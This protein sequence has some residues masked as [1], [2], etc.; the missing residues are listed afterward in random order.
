MRTFLILFLSLGLA[1]PAAAGELQGVTLPDTLDIEGHA[2]ALNGMALRKVFIVKVYVAGLY[3][4]EKSTDADAVL[5]ADTPR[6]ME[7]HWIH[8]GSAERVCEGWMEGLEDNTPD[9]SAELTGQFETLCEWTGAAEDGDVFTF[10]YLPGE[11]TTVKIN[12][13]ARGTAEGKAFADAL[14]A[15]WIGPEPGPGEKFKQNLMGS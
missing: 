2:L 6:H 1:L 7:M 14:F 12:G 15:V 8:D 5:A 4:P 11:G 10:T 9:A 3:L 13:E